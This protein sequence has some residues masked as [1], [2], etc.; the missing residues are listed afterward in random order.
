MSLTVCRPGCTRARSAHLRML[1]ALASEELLSRCYAAAPEHGCPWH[2][3]GD[4]AR[5]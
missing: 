3:F 4:T 5:R 1:A 2:E